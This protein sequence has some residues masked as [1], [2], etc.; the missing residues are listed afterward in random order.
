MRK[1]PFSYVNARF[2]IIKTTEGAYNILHKKT[3][4][5]LY[6]RMRAD[7]SDSLDTKT[8]YFP[9]IINYVTKQAK[10]ERRKKSSTRENNT[11]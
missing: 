4:P 7:E 1:S 3:S 9:G 2:N 11:N 8:E 6:Q 5:L 10:L